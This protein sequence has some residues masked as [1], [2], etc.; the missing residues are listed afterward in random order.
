MLN[1]ME[2]G[3]LFI[4][5]APAGTGKT[6]LVKKLTQEFPHVISSLSFTTR[7]P[8]NGEADGIDYNFISKTDFEERVKR[9]DLLEFVEL[10]GHYYGTS[11]KWVENQQAQGNHIVLVIDTQGGLLLKKK[12]VPAV[13]IFIEPPSLEELKRRL[14]ARKTE[15]L[16]VIE[17]RLS[18]VVREL[19]Q[20]AEYDYRIINDQLDVAYQVL[21]SIF[22]AE[23]HRIRKP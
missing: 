7:E 10:Y 23:M 11:K 22:I 21:K 18:C 9:G 14:L 4:V 15:S 16:T 20:G 5:S 8:R 12:N 2:K 17:E 6:T 3:L 13:F 1:K 19:Q